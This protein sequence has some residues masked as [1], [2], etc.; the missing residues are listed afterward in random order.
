MRTI[1]IAG[2]MTGI[3]GYNYPAFNAAAALLR[4]QGHTV[5]N[6]T[7]INAEHL[8]PLHPWDFYMRRNVA[9]LVKCNAIYLLEGWEKSKGARLEKE[10][11]A[12]LGMTLLREAE[13]PRGGYAN[14]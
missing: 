14:V 4:E 5:V 13:Y 9:E 1:Y 12:T 7:E 10:I 6:P 8:E 11:A 3:E 2:P